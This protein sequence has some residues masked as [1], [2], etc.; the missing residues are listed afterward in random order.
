MINLEAF[1]LLM[2]V[3]IK[4]KP[5]YLRQCLDSVL[6]STVLPDEIVIVKDGPVTNE[7]ETT[8]SQ[9]VTNYENLFKI[10]ALEENLGL[11]PALAEGI[12]HCRNEIVARMDT[13][14][15]VFP[16]RFEM[17]LKLFEKNSNLDIC[18]GH[19]IEFENDPAKPIAERRVPLTH[20]DILI[21]QKSR[22]SF[23]H[24]TVMY[25]KSKVILAGN[26]KN[27]PLME[28]DMLWIDMILSGA[29]CL[30]IDEYLCKVRTNRDMIARRGGIKYYK[31]YKYA[32]KLILDT[33]YINKKLYK[34][35]NII[36]FFVCIMPKWLRKFVFFNIIHKKVKDKN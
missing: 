21:Y 28:D 13:D 27:C 32:R 15:I 35:T 22:S 16:Y 17:Q 4:E 19:I 31:K 24:M 14:D 34:K 36:Q 6:N 7:I 1:S 8:L 33:G 5:E 30:N 26:Y 10:V 20:E 3:Y 23:N 11:G 12:K 9:Y 25:K 29:Y 2:S 18:G